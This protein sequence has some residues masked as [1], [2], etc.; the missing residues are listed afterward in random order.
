MSSSLDLPSSPDF[1]FMDENNNRMLSSAYK[2]IH[3]CEAWNIISN[4]KE[5]SFMF[6]QNEEI[7]NIMQKVAD[8]YTLHSGSSIGYTMRQIQ[9]IAK[10]GFTNYKNNYT[11]I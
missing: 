11:R 2:V 7:L 3:N 4:F 5:E 10:N 1:S 8:D 9:Y 6:T